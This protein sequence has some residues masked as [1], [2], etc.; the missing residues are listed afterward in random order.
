MR[1]ALLHGNRALSVE[2]V[3]EPR[4]APGDVVIE[5]AYTGICGTDLHEYASGPMFS[6]P[7]VVLGH[8]TAGTVVEVGAEIS[9]VRV[10]ARVTVI[11]MDFCGKCHYCRHALYHLCE[12]PG[13]IGFTRNGAFARY[14]AVPARLAVPVPDAV[15]LDVAALT[16]HFT[17]AFHAMRRAGLKIG[18]R[19]LVLGAGPVGLALLQC[20]AAAG[21]GEV[22]VTE[23][24]ARRART[25]LALGAAEVLDPASADVVERVRDRTGGIGVDIVFDAAGNQ[26]AVEQGLAALRKQGR[27]ASLCSWDRRAEIDMNRAL[28]SE[29]DIRF[30][31]GY[32]MFDDFPGVLSLMARG[33]LEAGRQITARIPLDNILDKG[34]HALLASRDEQVKILVEMGSQG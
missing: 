25:A 19:V 22:L 30:V 8:E 12:A 11:P 14:V 5:V 9:S 28:L 2:D 3:P 29:H 23:S 26:S 15:P 24:S 17:V 7:P 4:P 16:E 6:R 13:W 18:E 20:A 31:F 10:G 1:A 32:D 21:A 27:F 34:I 33:V